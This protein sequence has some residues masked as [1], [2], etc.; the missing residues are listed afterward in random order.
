MRSGAVTYRGNWISWVLFAAFSA[1]L[2]ETNRGEDSKPIPRAKSETRKSISDE[3][4]LL[5]S[6]EA[7]LV[8]FFFSHVLEYTSRYRDCSGSF[9]I[10]RI[11]Y[12]SLI[13]YKFARTF[14][15]DISGRRWLWWK[16]IA[17]GER[18]SRNA[19][20]GVVRD[21]PSNPK[22]SFA[23]YLRRSV[24]GMAPVRPIGPRFDVPATRT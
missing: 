24:C 13:I 7:S 5:S 17:R 12:K 8:F 1:I 3:H 18:K 9:T 2:R 10:R 22:A 20:K 19:G 6:F 23:L 21:D 11:T 15:R 16:D 14:P 4:K